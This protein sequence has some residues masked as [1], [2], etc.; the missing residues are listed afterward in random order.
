MRGN[1]SHFVLL[2]RSPETCPGRRPAANCGEIPMKAMHGTLCATLL[3]AAVTAHADGGGDV[4]LD[5]VSM[6]MVS[7]YAYAAPDYFDKSKQAAV[8][9]L[10]DRPIDAAAYDAAPDRNRAV[11]DVIGNMSSAGASLRITIGADKDG[12]AV[13]EGVDAGYRGEGGHHGTSMSISPS[14]YTLD[15]KANDGKRIEGTLRSTHESEKTEAHGHWFDL[16]FALDVASGPPFGPG[17]PPDGGE[18]YAGLQKYTSALS[19][20]EFSPDQE[21]LDGFANTI[22]DARLAAFNQF[23]RKAKGDEARVKAELS[24]MQ[25]ELPDSYEFDS[26]RVNGDVATIAIHAKTHDGDKANAAESLL[27]SMKKE[28]D[29]WVFDKVHKPGSSKTAAAAAPVGKKK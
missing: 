26:G 4:V 19:H 23:S 17:L 13:I 14:S 15:L 28:H 24:R 18:P 16:H 25:A 7:A 1:F 8:L 11:S 3:T 12:H 2:A 6:P 20:A 21:S 9:F 10:R 22:T 29:V 27:V 5:K